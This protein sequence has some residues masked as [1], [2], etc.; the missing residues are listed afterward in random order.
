MDNYLQT[1]CTSLLG[2]FLF[3]IFAFVD[4]HNMNDLGGNMGPWGVP[5]PN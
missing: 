2:F 1:S 5:Q 4:D 3:F